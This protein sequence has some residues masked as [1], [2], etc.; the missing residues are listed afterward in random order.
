METGAGHNQTILGAVEEFFRGKA[1]PFD[2]WP[3][4]SISKATDLDH[5]FRLVDRVYPVDESGQRPRQFSC[6]APD[7][8]HDSRLVPDQ[9]NK[10][11]KD[12]RRVR[13][14]VDVGFSDALLIEMVGVFR[15]EMLGFWDNLC[16]PLV[17]AYKRT[18]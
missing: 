13:R 15:S 5:S 14:I 18:C 6:A 17:E 2:V 8:E 7:V 4:T 9:A 12:L 10:Q 11:F 1:N 16:L 3:V